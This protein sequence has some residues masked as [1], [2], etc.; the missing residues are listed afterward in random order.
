MLR[1]GLEAC[2]VDALVVTHLPN[3]RY[4]CGF[5]GS[6]GVLLAASRPAFFTDGRYAEQAAQQVEGARVVVAKGGALTAAAE[7]C[8]RLRLTRVG[9]EADYLTVAQLR[10]LQ[11]A[12]G[13][14]VKLVPLSGTVEA[15]RVIKDA[16]EIELIRNAVDLSSRLF[17]PLLRSLRPGVAESAAAAR[18]ELLEQ[19]ACLLR[20]SLPPEA[21]QRCRTAWP[22]PRCC[23]PRGS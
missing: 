16:E 1:D 11:E 17:R 3:V 20:R 5:T 7:A 22:P 12:V 13:K 10:G 15:L 9:I 14:G 2:K 23:L 4:L 6:A 18:L 8:A 19:K 21:V